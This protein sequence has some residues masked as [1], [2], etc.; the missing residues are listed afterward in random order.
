MKMTKES[1]LIIGQ[2]CILGLECGSCNSNL[3]PYLIIGILL[4]SSRNFMPIDVIKNVING[5]SF[6]KVISDLLL[7]FGP[8]YQAVF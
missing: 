8:L 2:S 6:N 1:F 7:K 5:M 3:K 4:D